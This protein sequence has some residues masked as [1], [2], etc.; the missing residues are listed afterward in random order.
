MRP[1]EQPE[2]PSAPWRAASAVT[3]GAVGALCRGFLFGLSR[4]EVHGLEGFLK[5][6]DERRD[7]KERERGL[8]TVSN[9]VSVYV[10]LSYM[11][12]LGRGID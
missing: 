8:I 7:V 6:L 2:A 5:L 1:D 11:V 10:R 12:L 3:V 9:H 4:T